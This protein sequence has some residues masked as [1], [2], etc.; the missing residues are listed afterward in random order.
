MDTFKYLEGPQLWTVWIMWLILV[1]I[2]A[3]IFLNFLIAVISEL[4]AQVQE[5]RIEECYQKRAQL[6]V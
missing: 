1:V 2:N 3:M 4:Y 6:L 5:T